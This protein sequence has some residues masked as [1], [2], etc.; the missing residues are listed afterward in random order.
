MTTDLNLLNN[1]NLK[2]INEKLGS[3]LLK[4]ADKIDLIKYIYKTGSIALDKSL[5][6]GG[7]PSGKIIEIFGNEGCGKTTIALQT[8]K[9]AQK[10]QKRCLFIDAEH[11][12]NMSFVKNIGIDAS[13]LLVFSPNSGEQVFELL[14][15]VIKNKMVDLI[16]IDSVAAMV[17]EVEMINKIGD[18]QMGAHARLMSKGLRKIQTLLGDSD[19][20]IIFLNQV[21]EKIG[22]IFGN[23]EITTGG[24]ALRFYSSVRIEV[25]KSELI[26]DGL[27]KIG[28]KIK[29]NIIKSKLSAPM[30]T[31]F[32]DIY[33]SSGFDYQKEIIHFAIEN[34][35]IFKN[36]SWFSYNEQKLAQGKEKLYKY[37][38]LNPKLLAEIIKKTID[39][40]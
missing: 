7:F 31:A 26:K 39:V 15:Q 40:I 25:R 35:I 23:P 5:G 24:K 10:D 8:I 2:S 36:G 1:Q 33:F 18:Q 32:V 38:E 4:F 11:A 6:I 12:L 3:N 34:N 17:P 22:I 14:E 13:K 29:T 16:V 28:I 27:D 19:I 9:E 37:L 21:R 20:T 30:K